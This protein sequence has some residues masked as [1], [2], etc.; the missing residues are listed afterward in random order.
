MTEKQAQE[1]L[2]WSFDRNI[3]DPALRS[4][5]ALEYQ[6]H[7]LELIE[8]RLEQIANAMGKGYP[9]INVLSE[10]QQIRQNLTPKG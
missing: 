7:Y 9:K 2:A 6:A 1:K 8:T 3:T 10:L 4:A 5:R